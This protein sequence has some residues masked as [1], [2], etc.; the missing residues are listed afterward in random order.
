[1]GVLSVAGS[2]RSRPVSFERVGVAAFGQQPDAAA[3]E[4]QEAVQQP[5]GELDGVD[6][7]SQLGGWV[8]CP[9]TET[10]A[11]VARAGA[12]R[13]RIANGRPSHAERSVGDKVEISRLTFFSTLANSGSITSSRRSLMPGSWPVGSRTEWISPSPEIRPVRIRR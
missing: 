1:M 6:V 2:R 8:M 12:V 13:V 3:A 5:V 10:C 7:V 9:I 4:Q 11:P